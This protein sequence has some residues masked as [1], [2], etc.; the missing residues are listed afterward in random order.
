ML[1]EWAESHD[2]SV[3]DLYGWPNGRTATGSTDMVQEADSLVPLSTALVENFVE[4]EPLEVT[5]L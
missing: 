5:K 3:A 2:D 1:V 4:K